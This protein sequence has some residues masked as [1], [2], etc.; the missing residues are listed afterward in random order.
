MKRFL[1]LACLA[2]FA[3]LGFAGPPLKIP[4]DLK[5]VA[6]YVRFT[7]E[8]TAKSVV[9]IPLD[10]AYPFPSEELKD[11]RRFILPVIG[12]KDATYRFAAV[13]TLDDEQTVAFFSVTIGKGGTA[14]VDPPTDPAPTPNAKFMFLIIRPDGPAAPEFV[15]AMKNG[16]WANHRKAGRL[17][18]DMTL[19]ESIGVYKV[20]AGTTIPMVVTLKIVDD[21]S[22]VASGPIPLPTTSEGIKNLEQGAK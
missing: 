4:S 21:K 6:G 17:V 12:L 13:G 20:P 15:E 16:E 9:Y 8:T 7:P 22:T 11:P 3:A 18:K 2:V 1:P 5:P 19:T 14:P 10:A